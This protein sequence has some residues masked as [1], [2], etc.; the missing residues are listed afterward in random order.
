MPRGQRD[1]CR[2]CPSAPPRCREHG[3]ADTTL[4]AGRAPGPR[5]RR[6]GQRF[7]RTIVA[8]HP[9]RSDGASAKAATSGWCASSDWTIPR[10]TPIPRPWINRTS[11]KPRAWAA[12]RYSE[13][14]DG[15]S[16]GANACRSSASSIGTRTGSSPATAAALPARAAS[17]GRSSGDPP[18]RACTVRRSRRARRRSRPPAQRSRRARSRR[19]SATPS[20]AR[21][22]SGS[23]RDGG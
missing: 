16:R 6:T 15:M 17:S 8:P 3:F 12:S 21:T 1:P 22:E 5:V 10:W 23:A 19:P 9:P 7:N 4:A 2:A 20:G 13:T 18:P 11:V 14:T